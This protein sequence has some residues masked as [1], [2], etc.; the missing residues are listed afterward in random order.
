MARREKPRPFQTIP[1]SHMQTNLPPKQGSFVDRSHGQYA[2]LQSSQSFDQTHRQV[3]NWSSMATVQAFDNPPRRAQSFQHAQAFGQNFQSQTPAI[4]SQHSQHPLDTLRPSAS[5]S[6]MS[7]QAMPLMGEA[8]PAAALCRWPLFWG[9]LATLLLGACCG[10]LAMVQLKG[11]P[12]GSLRSQV[13]AKAL[14]L[15]PDQPDSPGGQRSTAANASWVP[16]SP[17]RFDC[18]AVPAAWQQVWPPAKKAFCCERPGSTCPALATAAAT[19]AAPVRTTPRSFNCRVGY[20]HWQRDWTPEKK[21]W[22]CSHLHVACALPAAAALARPADDAYDCVAGLST[23]EQ[24]WPPDKQ[25]W[26]CSKHGRGC[27]ATTTSRPAAFD[28]NVDGATPLRHWLEDRRIWCCQHHGVACLASSPA[29]KAGARLAPTT[30]PKQVEPAK[31]LAPSGGDKGCEESCRLNGISATC[32]QR[33]R[34]SVK[35][36]FEGDPGACE[37]AHE[38]LMKQCPVCSRCSRSSLSSLGC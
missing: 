26:C 25:R 22:C 28:C 38:L 35:H 3:Q 11:D 36:Q 24:T 1:S 5:G 16:T 20:A 4:S 21:R 8:H 9:L 33:I 31:T 29:S 7:S 30:T 17:P 18:S 32:T 10:A 2:P 19:T 37:Q 34:Y 15:H 6:K 23:W 12:G 13:L 27:A 14:M